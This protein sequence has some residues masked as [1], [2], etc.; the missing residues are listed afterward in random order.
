MRVEAR[1]NDMSVTARIYEEPG[2]NGHFDTPSLSGRFML[3]DMSEHACKVTNLAVVGA[4]FLTDTEVPPGTGIVAYLEDLGR[5]EAISGQP[6]DGGFDIAFD[7]KGSRQEKLETRIKWLNQRQFGSDY[8]R[9][10]PRYEPRDNKS[11]MT[12]PDGRV[13]DCEV[14]DISL[15]GAA[16]TI[17]VRPSLG[18][19]IML[20]RIRGQIVRH[21]ENA[22]GIEFTKA[23][24]N[25]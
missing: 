25:A 5:V 14:Q 2:S 18:T 16:V 1:G 9:R 7:I 15:S 10:H 6:V 4:T 24:G 3:P 20:G 22:V 11:Q 19:Y 21:I 8:P 13:F 23:F 12:L 17:D